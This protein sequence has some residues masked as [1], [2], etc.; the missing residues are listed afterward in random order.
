VRS[1][2]AELA[3]R[4]NPILDEI[5]ATMREANDVRLARHHQAASAA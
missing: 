1:Q 2:R 5:A 3:Q 4:F